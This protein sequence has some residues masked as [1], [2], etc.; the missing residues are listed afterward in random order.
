MGDMMNQVTYDTG[1]ML[2]CARN[3]EKSMDSFRKKHKKINKIVNEEVPRHTKDPMVQSYQKDMLNWNRMFLNWNR[4]WRG[5]SARC[6]LL[7]IRLQTQ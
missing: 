4:R 7:Q 6:V 3:M 2:R 5:I 1:E